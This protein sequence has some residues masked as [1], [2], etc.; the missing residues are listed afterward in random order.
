MDALPFI[1]STNHVPGWW[2]LA[3]IAI[4]IWMLIAQI[5][6]AGL[7]AGILR[8]LGGIIAWV[9]IWYFLTFLGVMIGSM[10]DHY[11]RATDETNDSPYSNT[12]EDAP[13]NPGEY[14]DPN[15]HKY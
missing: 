3:L 1:E 2:Q 11:E 9:I 15:E 10:A 8:A 7:V 5:R 6:R 12:Y 4:P 14:Y 13:A